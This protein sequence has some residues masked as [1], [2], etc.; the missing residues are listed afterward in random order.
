MSHIQAY[1]K[2]LTKLFGGG[3]LVTTCGWNWANLK[4][5]LCH[6][7]DTGVMWDENKLLKEIC[8]NP[9]FTMALL[10][11]PPY[12]LSNPLTFQG[13]RDTVIFTYKD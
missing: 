10:G 13:D 5:V 9:M 4:D 11:M 6:N 8:S 2:I 1:H 7:P 12:W 3:Q